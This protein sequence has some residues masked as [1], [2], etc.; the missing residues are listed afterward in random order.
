MDEVFNILNKFIAH[1]FDFAKEQKTKVI[2]K[3]SY[4][5]NKLLEKHLYQ[6]YYKVTFIQTLTFNLETFLKNTSLEIPAEKYSYHNFELSII[7]KEFILTLPSIFSLVDNI[8]E[9][10]NPYYF[11]YGYF[12]LSEKNN[13]H[14]V[15]MYFDLENK[16]IYLCDPNGYTTYFDEYLEE[17]SEYIAGIMSHFVTELNKSGLNFKYIPQVDWI[18][19]KKEINRHLEYFHI[20][21]GGNCYLNT[22]LIC[23]FLA[24]RY[25]PSNIYDIF[26]KLNDE[27]YC[28]VLSK[29]TSYVFFENIDL[30]ISK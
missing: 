9:C 14:A 11:L 21:D 5:L 7:G 10:K 15:M 26:N 4:L 30:F 22:F 18:K 23:F 13:G 16:K 2:K 28:F 3:G 24:N 17:S 12:A 29:V 19:N 8:L 20:I 27:E 6:K 25:E 1:D